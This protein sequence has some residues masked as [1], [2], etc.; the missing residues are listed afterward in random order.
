LRASLLVDGPALNILATGP[1]KPV[2]ELLKNGNKNCGRETAEE[3]ERA[4][5]Q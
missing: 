5:R 2:W 4:K 3:K 1:M